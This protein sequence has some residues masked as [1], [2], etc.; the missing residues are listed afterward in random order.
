[1]DG[2]LLYTYLLGASVACS[3]VTAVGAALLDSLAFF[4]EQPSTGDRQHTLMVCLGVLALCV[5]ALLAATM[6]R[7]PSTVRWICVSGIAVSA[8]VAYWAFGAMQVAA[9]DDFPDPW[10]TGLR[11]AV[12]AFS[13]WPLLA[14]LVLSPIFR[15]SRS[16]S[17]RRP[18]PIVVPR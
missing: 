12:V 17:D 15:P 3:M 16:R 5:L 4:G 9:P 11:D 8:V 1:M 13:D 14:C 7:L 10:W 2:R 6:L 18:N